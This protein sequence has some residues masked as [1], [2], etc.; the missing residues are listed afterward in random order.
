MGGLPNPALL[1]NPLYLMQASAISRSEI[2]SLRQNVLKLEA[3]RQSSPEMYG[4]SICLGGSDD[5]STRQAQHL[6]LSSSFSSA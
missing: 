3:N 4:M 1:H 5:G 2:H 6:P